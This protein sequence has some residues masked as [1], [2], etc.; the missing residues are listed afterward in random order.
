[1]A[2]LPLTGRF[3][4]QQPLEL[5]PAGRAIVANEL[6][7]APTMIEGMHSAKLRCQHTRT[8]SVSSRDSSPLPL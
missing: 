3:P 7:R 4:T 8:R 1:M 2:L 5:L 6:E